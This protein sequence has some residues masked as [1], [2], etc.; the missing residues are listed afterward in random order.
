M[1]IYV[2]KS[3]FVAN[4][5]VFNQTERYCSTFEKAIKFYNATL[6]NLISENLDMVNDKENYEIV[7]NGN[8]Y[9]RYYCCYYKYQFGAS[10]FYVE[11]TSVNVE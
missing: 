4:G 6:A 7:K 11:L 8:K 5:M 3:N 2:V 10:N 9:S 1:K